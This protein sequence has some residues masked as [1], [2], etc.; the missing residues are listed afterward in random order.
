MFTSR[1][2]NSSH[3]SLFKGFANYPL[4]VCHLVW[5]PNFVPAVVAMGTAEAAAAAAPADG[6]PGRAHAEVQWRRRRQRREQRRRSPGRPP[7]SVPDAV[8]AGLHLPHS[9]REAAEPGSTGE[10]QQAALHHR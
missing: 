2:K 4:I 10:Q 8:V 9:A 1:S 7:A 3:T 6:D 5:P